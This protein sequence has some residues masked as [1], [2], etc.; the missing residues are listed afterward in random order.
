MV[1]ENWR[2]GKH[3]LTRKD[4]ACGA[5]VLARPTIVQVDMII[6]STLKD[7]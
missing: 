2:R 3:K 4:F 5:T 1:L 6:A 7:Y